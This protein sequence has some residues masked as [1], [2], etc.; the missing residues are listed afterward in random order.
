MKQ[1]NNSNST[2]EGNHQPN[3]N[4]ELL[5]EFFFPLDV[6]FEGHMV[7]KG[8]EWHRSCVDDYAQSLDDY[9]F[10]L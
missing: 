9:K 10:K 8:L 6:N 5:L 3:S 7:F 4:R 1:K 2:Q